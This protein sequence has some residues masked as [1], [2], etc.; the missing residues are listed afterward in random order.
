[1]T[2][3]TPEQ[4]AALRAVPVTEDNPNRLRVAMALVQAR[5][6]DLSEQTGINRS[7]ISRIVNGH[8]VNLELGTARAIAEAFGCAIEDLFPSQVAA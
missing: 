5:G 6:D 4:I 7:H 3:L 1:M 8:A 2:Q